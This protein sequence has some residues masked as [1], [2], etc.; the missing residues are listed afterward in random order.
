MQTCEDIFVHLK[1]QFQKSICTATWM[2]LRSTVLSERS[3]T[4]RLHTLHFHLHG[5]LEKAKAAGGSGALPA[6]GPEGAFKG[7]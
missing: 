3:Q 1:K 4:Q 6:G 5:I 2:N 7:M